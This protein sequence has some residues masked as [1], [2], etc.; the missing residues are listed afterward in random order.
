VNSEQARRSLIKNK[1]QTI[2]QIKKQTNE[3]INISEK[4]T[5]VTGSDGHHGT[6]FRRESA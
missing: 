1:N 3:G 5:A 2:Q 6:G 4:T